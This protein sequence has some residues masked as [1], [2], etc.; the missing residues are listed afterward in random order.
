MEDEGGE[1]VVQK[2]EGGR[3]LKRSERKSGGKIREQAGGRRLDT[4]THIR[5]R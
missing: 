1:E 3:K 4:H 5:T 2:E